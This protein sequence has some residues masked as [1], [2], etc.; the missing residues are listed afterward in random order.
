MPMI[1]TSRDDLH[2]WS[3][4]PA[5]RVVV[6]QEFLKL[7]HSRSIAVYTNPMYHRRTLLQVPLFSKFDSR[8][9][10]GPQKTHRPRNVELKLL[11]TIPGSVKDEND[12][13][14]GSL[15]YC[16]DDFADCLPIVYVV[17]DRYRVSDLRSY[18]VEAGFSSGCGHHY[19]FSCPFKLTG[20]YFEKRI[21]LQH[22]YLTKT[23]P[24]KRL[25]NFDGNLYILQHRQRGRR[26]KWMR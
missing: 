26:N 14:V 17:L 9:V 21:L 10:E 8:T 5:T 23:V 1:H 20:S 18:V 24:L 25:H 16:S 7:R 13:A 4:W 2:S 12:V 22:T 11:K 6:A 15:P 19:S 3:A